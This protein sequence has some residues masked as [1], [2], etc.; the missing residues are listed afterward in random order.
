MKKTLTLK[1]ALPRPRNPVALAGRMRAAGRHGGGS[2][3]QRQAEGR[4][5]RA[6]LAALH[7][8]PRRR[9]A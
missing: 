9:D 7:P 6:E 2:A 8:P 5:L 1:L 3:R 4:H